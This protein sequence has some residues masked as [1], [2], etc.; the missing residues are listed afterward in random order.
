MKK[1]KRI[2]KHCFPVLSVIS[3]LITLL[4]TVPVSAASS[5]SS[6]FGIEDVW[7]HSC[8]SSGTAPVIELRF[9][10]DG[11]CIDC[12]ECGFHSLTPYPDGFVGFSTDS[13]ASTPDSSQ[14]DRF[15]SEASIPFSIGGSEKNCFTNLFPCYE[16]ETYTT[17]VNF[18]NADGTQL[19]YATRFSSSESAVNVSFRLYEDSCILES[20]D[21]QSKI[22]YFDIDNF[23]GFSLSSSSLFVPGDETTFIGS[24]CSNF[25]LFLATN[26][27]SDRVRFTVDGRY[28]YSCKSGR[29]WRTFIDAVNW[30]VSGTTFSIDGDVVVFSTSTGRYSLDLVDPDDPVR[31]MDYQISLLSEQVTFIVSIDGSDHLFSCDKGMSFLE[32]IQNTQFPVNGFSFRA[33]PESDFLYVT[34]GFNTWQLDALAV[35][36]VTDRT[37]LTKEADL[38]HVYFYIDGK[39]FYCTKGRTWAEFIEYVDW[40]TSGGYSLRAEGDIYFLAPYGMYKVNVESVHDVIQPVFYDVTLI[41]PIYPPELSLDGDFL[42]LKCTDDSITQFQLYVDG[43]ESVIIDRVG[44]VTV[45]DI[46]TLDL[47]GGFKYH[48]TARSIDKNGYI[49]PSGVDYGGR[50]FVSWDLRGLDY[51]FWSFSVYDTDGTKVSDFS[52]SGLNFTSISLIVSEDS[53]T[54]TDGVI[55]KSFSKPGLKYVRCSDGNL[56][57]VGTHTISSSSDVT[58][59][60]FY[61][62]TDYEVAGKICYY[63]KDGI[64]YSFLEYVP[65]GYVLEIICASNGVQVSIGCNGK[66][67]ATEFYPYD[68]RITKITGTVVIGDD[69]EVFELEPDLQKVINPIEDFCTFKIEINGSSPSA[70]SGLGTPGFSGST[71]VLYADFVAFG[72]FVTS[73]LGGF[74]AFEIAPGLS[75]NGMF[76]FFLVLGIALFLIKVF[77]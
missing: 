17:R 73:V 44:D 66:Y 76:S 62:V 13:L 22:Y 36:Q 8:K 70:G 16:T 49:S 34:D 77:S 20:L 72:T 26:D 10:A 32:W 42:I 61:A 40:P 6:Y 65:D 30:P 51:H 9:T 29:T 1:I 55:S 28:S 57:P 27:A 15:S 71:S 18:Y 48:I 63:G 19:L 47:P 53:F 45:F 21:G 5:Y 3:L 75:F 37:Y 7:V 23:L 67:I 46:R 41:S 52:I 50:D 24:E 25:N 14:L 2:L 39:R 33:D 69:V 60:D 38:E 31:A 56:Y 35:D 43:T 11:Y 59:I 68:G 64:V 4:P 54:I 58:Y 74:L 12:Q